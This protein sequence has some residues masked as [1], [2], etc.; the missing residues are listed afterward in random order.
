MSSCTIAETKNG[1]S[2]ILAAL[3]S[4]AEREHIIKNRDVPV[5]VILPYNKR[6]NA[7]RRFGFA[8]DD[9]KV[10]DWEMFDDMDHDIAEEFGV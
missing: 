6:P 8:K 10:I 3:E 9:G 5:A 1:L 7:P 2:A 4:G